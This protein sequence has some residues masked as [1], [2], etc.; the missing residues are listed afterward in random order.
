MSLILKESNDEPS[1]TS[2]GREFHSLGEADLKD[3]LP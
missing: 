3:I 1:Q 2:S